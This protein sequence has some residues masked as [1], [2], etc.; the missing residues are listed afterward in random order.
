MSMIQY[1]YIHV[2]H[3]VKVKVEKPSWL[4][5][6]WIGNSNMIVLV[7]VISCIHVHSYKFSFHT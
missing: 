4:F 7:S 6:I 1:M 5:A 2:C 3:N